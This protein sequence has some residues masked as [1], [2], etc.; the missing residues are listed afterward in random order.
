MTC[1]MLSSY[2]LV[3]GVS[4]RVSYDVVS[5]DEAFPLVRRKER[6]IPQERVPY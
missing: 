6:H 5:L 4:R 1:E 2:S 3:S